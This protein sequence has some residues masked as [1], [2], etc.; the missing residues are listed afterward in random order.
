MLTL[1][2]VLSHGFYPVSLTI[3]FQVYLA[4]V[5]VFLAVGPAIS[6]LVRYDG[7]EQFVRTHY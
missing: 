4:I 1:Y 5:S 7:S 6:F 2:F 3:Y